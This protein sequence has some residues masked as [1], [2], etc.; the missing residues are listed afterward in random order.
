MAI[1]TLLGVLCAALA[2]VAIPASAQDSTGSAGGDTT[3][4]DAD[5]TVLRF[6]WAQEPD[7]LNPFV[8]QNEEDFTIWSINWDLPIGFSPKDLSPVPAIAQD[9]EVSDDRK[10]VTM[11]IDPDL[12]W[13]D[14]KPITSEDVKWS[15][16]VLGGE[17]QTA[18]VVKHQGPDG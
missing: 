5:K 4:A 14:G 9:W 2:V 3:T 6:G 17:R 15:L 10:T 13:S 1:A 7:N 8:G 16:D 12:K 18:A 11:T